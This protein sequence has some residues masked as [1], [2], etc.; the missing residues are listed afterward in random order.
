MTPQ[1]LPEGCVRCGP[2]QVS[3]ESHLCARL[4]AHILQMSSPS[5][6]SMPGMEAKMPFEKQDAGAQDLWSLARVLIQ[7]KAGFE[8]RSDQMQ[9][10]SS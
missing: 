7:A 1:C 5:I 8:F 10:L 6:P 4:S 2:P 3:I 9:S